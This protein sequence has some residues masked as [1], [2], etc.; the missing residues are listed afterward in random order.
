MKLDGELSLRIGFH[1]WFIVNKP[2]DELE[3]K[4][5]GKR[6]QIIRVEI[7]IGCEIYYLMNCHLIK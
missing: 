5:K 3:E 1:I 6:N 2:D 4:K 7:K